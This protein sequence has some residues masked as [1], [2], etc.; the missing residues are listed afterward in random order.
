MFK[1]FEYVTPIMRK[2]FKLNLQDLS[3]DQI[4]SFEIMN[5]H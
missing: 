3:I 1:E 4:K 2:S 5:P